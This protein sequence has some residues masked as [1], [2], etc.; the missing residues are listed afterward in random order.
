MFYYASG[1]LNFLYIAS[2]YLRL[3]RVKNKFQ[4]HI[5]KSLPIK[6]LQNSVSKAA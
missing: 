2:V 1:D 6:Q 4:Q 5:R 3:K